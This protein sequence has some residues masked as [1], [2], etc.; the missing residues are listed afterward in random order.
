MIELRPFDTLGGGDRCWLR[1]KHHFAFA[2]YQ[3]ST[4][5]RWGITAVEDFGVISVDG[6]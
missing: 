6:A 5:R 3:D 4:R 2:D 1:T